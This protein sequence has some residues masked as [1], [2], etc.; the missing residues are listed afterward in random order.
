MITREKFV[1][2]LR[3][4][5]SDLFSPTAP[6]EYVYQ[7]GKMAFPNIEVEDWADATASMTP[8][9]DTSPDGWNELVFKDINDDSWEWVKHAYSNSLQGTLEQ[10]KNGKLDYDIKKDYDELNVGEKILSGVA[11]FL[12]PLDVV[13]LFGGGLASRGAMAIGKKAVG[14]KLTESLAGR[15]F[16]TKLNTLGVKRGLGEGVAKGAIERAIV[17]GN[18]LGMY[19]A[20]KGALAADNQGGDVTK[21]ISDG[22]VHGALMGAVFGGTGGVLE[23]NFLKYKALKELKGGFRGLGE[24]GGFAKRYTIPELEKLMK[25]TGPLPQYAAEV[26][27]LEAFTIADA[28]KNSELKGEKLLED[29]VVNVGFA[30]LMRGKRKAIGELAKQYKK[31]KSQYEKDFHEKELQ[32]LRGDERP[33]KERLEDQGYEGLRKVKEEAKRDGDTKLEE[34]IEEGMNQFDKNR[35]P[36]KF[37]KNEY[38]ENLIEFDKIDKE[39]IALESVLGEEIP[40]KVVSERV[41]SLKSTQNTMN[42]VIGSLDKLIS[43]GHIT[44]IEGS[45]ARA[46]LQNKIVEH[47]NL[48]NK[49]L[50][51]TT[52][53][54]SRLAEKQQTAR[55]LFD[56]LKSKMMDKKGEVSKEF[57]DLIVEDKKT[58][59]ELIKTEKGV[60]SFIRG[61]E[62]ALRAL[63]KKKPES[64]ALTAYESE[65]S[66]PLTR[67]EIPLKDIKT[68][69]VSRKKDLAD[70]IR[71]S[72]ISEDSMKKIA[73]GVKKFFRESNGSKKDLEQ[74]IDYAKWL[75]SKGLKFGEGHGSKEYTEYL[76]DRGLFNNKQI[77]T[78]KLNKFF[79]TVHPKGKMDIAS[80]K[81]YAGM[82]MDRAVDVIKIEGGWGD[83]KKGAAT[84]IT[85]KDAVKLSK[86]INNFS[87]QS[88]LKNIGSNQ[89]GT[90]QKGLIKTLFDTFYNV[91][92]RIS[93]MLMLRAEDVN[94]KKGT[95]RFFVTKQRNKEQFIGKDGSPLM[96]KGK[97]ITGEYQEIPLAKIFPELFKQLK[98]LKRGKADKDFIFTTE[99]GKLL[100]QTSVNGIL[101]HIISKSGVSPIPIRG[102]EKMTS[103]HFRH[104]A[105]VDSEAIFRETGKDYRNLAKEILLFQKSKPDAIEHYKDTKYLP[106]DYKNFLKDRKK[107]KEVKESDIKKAEEIIG[108]EDIDIIRQVEKKPELPTPPQE[109]QR[110]V[111]DK[112]RETKEIHKRVRKKKDVLEH[113]QPQNHKKI[114]DQKDMIIDAL[115]GAQGAKTSAKIY[116][117]RYIRNHE[118]AIQE[119]KAN[120]TKTFPPLFGDTIWH[121]SQIANY[122]QALNLL[123]SSPKQGMVEI[124]AYRG[125]GSGERR[126]LTNLIKKEQRY[127]GVERKQLGDKAYEREI[128][129]LTKNGLGYEEPVSS[130]SKLTTEDLYTFLNLLRSTN[131][132]KSGAK[133]KSAEASV[134]MMA[135]DRGVTPKQLEEMLLEVGVKDGKFENVASKQVF[136][137]IKA[138]LSEHERIKLPPSA[139]D[140]IVTFL[141]SGFKKFPSTFRRTFTP[142]YA[143]LKNPKIG[144]EVGGKIA[145]KFLD[146]DV[147]QSLLNGRS[148]RDFIKIRGLLGDKAHMLQFFDKEKRKAWKKEMTKEELD[149]VKKMD[150]KGTKE[151]EAAQ[152]WDTLRRDLYKKIELYT[153]QWSNKAIDVELKQWMDRKFVDDYFT[154]RVSKEFLEILPEIKDQS[155]MEEVFSQNMNSYVRGK[156]NAM[157]IGKNESQLDFNNR[158]KEKEISIRKNQKD[159][160]I[161]KDR[162]MTF[163][164]MPHHKVLNKNL[165][166]RGVLLPRTVEVSIKGKRKKIN[167][168]DES[169]RGSAEYYGFS[170]GKYL[171]TLRHFPEVTSL[172]KE[173]K[174]GN[175]K[176]NIFDI[177]TS[178]K[179]KSKFGVNR[180]W[181]D[182]LR[183]ALETHLGMESSTNSRIKKKNL[184]WMGTLA[185]TGAAAGL[186]TPLVHGIKNLGLAFTASSRHY[187]MRNTF[188]GF[189]R[190]MNLQERAKMLEKGV[191]E[192]MSTNIL[193]TQKNIFEQMGLDKKL[194]FGVGKWLTMDRIFD[195]N[196]MKKSEE[197]GR[198]SSAFAGGMYFHQMLGAY[199]GEANSF[200]MGKARTK[201][202]AEFAF[203]NQFKLSQEEINFLK[204]TKLEELVN[205]KNEN[206]L[207]K[208]AW[209]QNKVE[210]FSHVSSQGGTSTFLLPLWMSQPGYKPL[211]LFSRI[212]T[213]A[214]HDLWQNTFRPLWNHGNPMPLIR[215]AAASTFTG[216]G[217]YYFYKHIMGQDQM[218]EKSDSKWKTLA[219]YLWRAE[220]LGL[221]TS[222]IN[223]HSSPIYGKGKTGSL[224]VDPTFVGDFFEPYMLRSARATVEGLTTLMTD[225]TN[226]KAYSQAI[227]HITKNTVSGV[228]QLG[229]QWDRLI[230]PELHEWRGFRT[231]A[232]S[233]KKEKGYT[234]P[235][236]VIQTAR[237]IYYKDLKDTFWRGNEEDFAKTYY[238]A[239]SYIDSDMLEGGFVNPSF[240]RKESMKR[241]EQSLKT[242]NPVNFSDESKGRVMSKKREFLQYLKNNNAE[243]YRRA[244]KA[245]REFNFKL[246]KLLASVNKS[247]YKL[248]YSPYYDRY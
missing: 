231:A 141:T 158:K 211:T 162:V 69:I 244:I 35:T 122:K 196:F 2:D 157:K 74:V 92:K 78:K 75:E 49:Y 109:P 37:K 232:R 178:D 66:N 42:K 11:S 47:R 189:L 33:W 20:A 53:T 184:R 221:W 129:E 23:G 227:K 216:A 46:W 238:D 104:S 222:L 242:L 8:K 132:S 61:T 152:I 183:L 56:S 186:S 90:V 17:E 175:W 62:K 150:T 133:F 160:D 25:Y 126:K 58:F 226:P 131:Y 93:E 96:K 125:Q 115:E 124:G 180:D 113:Y 164:E 146:F 195:V 142:M 94:T 234:I 177:L 77:V 64:D 185:S 84:R 21:A 123:K 212:A 43:D 207:K 48:E 54:E 192:Y 101:S 246:R 71:E 106:S 39:L 210:H 201:K 28:A 239:L 67:E 236:A 173:L 117:G 89:A 120:P 193:R 87:K 72:G 172:G 36:S 136:D 14:K 235:S 98:N 213:S 95:V 225:P 247:K 68:N 4:D 59:N 13:T 174:L 165:M 10:W 140:H 206:N 163:L 34:V 137:S 149:F 79:G 105:V 209:I 26:A 168:Y 100:T 19:E 143:L 32:Q 243:E 108:K 22:Y 82:F 182:Y 220:F 214:T 110:A 83:V 40:T 65:F 156:L 60:D 16:L 147:T 240:R 80:K 5:Y 76:L 102:G 200:F 181:A 55:T 144:G 218:F 15:G 233:F 155:F 70:T 202:K 245:E 118:K 29:L 191:G 6:D 166:D 86:E 188:G 194:P 103:H 1:S 167:T 248:R 138:M 9:V 215:H 187:G 88:S 91:P 130:I 230:Y 24:K 127:L 176:K 148:S 197:I 134:K 135:K 228:G 179:E 81:G 190:Y 30:G 51:K 229:R 57:Q 18:T 171:A 208:M 114:N 217:L 161:V 151:Y 31:G 198:I 116:L 38:L 205:P 128:R 45:N 241:I 73:I 44:E 63:E 99:G 112:I 50:H 219:Q 145:D 85:Y 204:N 41:G 52:E 223:P 199:K 154:R 237:S 97:P 153:K 224:G 169:F 159:I 121:Q 203:K 7:T 170:M 12:M 119:I 27:A 139:S 111:I 3:R 107:I